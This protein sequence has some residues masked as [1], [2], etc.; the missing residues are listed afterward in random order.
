MSQELTLS[1]SDDISHVLLSNCL[2]RMVV[3][4]SR[5]MKRHLKNLL[6]IISIISLIL[7]VMGNRTTEAMSSFLK[8]EKQDSLILPKGADDLAKISSILQSEHILLD[9]WSFYAREHV[10]SMKSMEEM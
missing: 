3:R 5:E 4:G 6:Y 1:K 9:D 2:A 10:T 8:S 7:V